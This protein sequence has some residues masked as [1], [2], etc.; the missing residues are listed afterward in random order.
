MNTTNKPTKRNNKRNRVGN[1]NKVEE[2]NSLRD[3]VT[4]DPY[5]GE[6][7]IDPKAL[8]KYKRAKYIKPVSLS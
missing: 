6:P 4:N 5:P 8:R 2:I 7:P 3:K 1:D